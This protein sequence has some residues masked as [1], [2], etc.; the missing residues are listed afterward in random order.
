M[1]THLSHVQPDDG[2]SLVGAAQLLEGGGEAGEG[3][4]ATAVHLQEEGSENW[5]R[6]TVPACSP[7]LV[8]HHCNIRGHI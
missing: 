3:W 7:L 1:R 6:F 2:G 5:Q 4:L 8:H